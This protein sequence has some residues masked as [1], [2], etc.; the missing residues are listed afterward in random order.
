[1]L[2]LS[3]SLPDTIARNHRFCGHSGLNRFWRQKRDLQYAF[4]LYIVQIYTLF[5]LPYQKPFESSVISK[6][7]LPPRRVRQTLQ[8]VGILVVWFV[9]SIAE[10][11]GKREKAL[12]S[13][14][15]PGVIPLYCMCPDPERNRIPMPPRRLALKTQPLSPQAL[16]HSFPPGDCGLMSSPHGSVVMCGSCLWDKHNQ[17]LVKEPTVEMIRVDAVDCFFLLLALSPFICRLLLQ[18]VFYLLNIVYPLTSWF[19]FFF[20]LSRHQSGQACAVSPWAPQALQVQTL[21]L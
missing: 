18:S 11:E 12:I 19:P 8:R 15:L 3:Q 1:M 13:S 14:E 10:W 6:N 20:V 7:V 17:V 21:P 2:T 5:F 9:L 4:I 16:T